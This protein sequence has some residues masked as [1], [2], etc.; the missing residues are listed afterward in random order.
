MSNTYTYILAPHTSINY[1]VLQQAV[2]SFPDLVQEN[3]V[4]IVFKKSV[5][6]L[7][8]DD[9]GLLVP[10]DSEQFIY[11][12]ATTAELDSELLGQVTG[13]STYKIDTQPFN[14][15]WL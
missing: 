10:A 2:A 11:M 5:A 14:E 4:K 7:I 15:F 8:N 1:G 13:Y 6:D 3:R 12:K 9:G